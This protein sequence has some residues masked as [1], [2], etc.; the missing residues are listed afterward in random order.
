L[1]PK[2]VEGFYNLG[3]V[4]RR[5]GQN[6]LAIQAYREA[7]RVNPR[8]ADA[9]LNLANLYLEKKQFRLAIQHYEEADKLR[10][11]WQKAEE[12]LAH[13]PAGVTGEQ[14]V[15]GTAA[16]AT[17]A[18][19]LE[20]VVDPVVHAEFLERLHSAAIEADEIGRRLQSVLAAEV[21]GTVKELSIC[22]L[23]QNTARHS[24]DSCL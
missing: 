1:D 10:P 3:L 6:D 5:K 22:L 2:R 24:L 20:R 16:Q 8:M 11:G 23:Q 4:Y 12:G 7:I 18:K 14:R 9:Q 19:E 21:E 15:T 13:A 17:S